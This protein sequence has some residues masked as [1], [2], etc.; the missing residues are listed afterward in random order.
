MWESTWRRPT[1]SQT[2]ISTLSRRTVRFAE[3]L[4]QQCSQVKEP[5]ES[6][7]VLCDVD[8]CKDQYA[9]V[10]AAGGMASFHDEGHG[11]CSTRVKALGMD[12]DPHCLLSTHF[13]FLN[14]CNFVTALNLLSQ[15]SP[16]EARRARET[17]RERHS[18]I[19]RH[20][21]NITQFT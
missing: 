18:V 5:A 14:L 6:T 9:N 21:Q 7:A 4:L 17:L 2:V 8:I 15:M 1:F 12:E 19:A 10:V 20:G 11:G 13:S 3:V 16:V